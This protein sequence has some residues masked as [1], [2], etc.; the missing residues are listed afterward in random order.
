MSDETY[1]KDLIRKMKELRVSGSGEIII[2]TEK[3]TGAQLTDI[4]IPFEP[5]DFDKLNAEEKEALFIWLNRDN[6]PQA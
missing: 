1:L 3:N 4:E 6:M 5:R 2:P